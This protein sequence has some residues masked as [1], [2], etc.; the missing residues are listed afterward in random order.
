MRTKL[1]GSTCR[2]K[3][4]KNSVPVRVI[5]LCLPRGR[6]P[7]TGTSRA[8]VR[9]PTSGDWKSPRG[10]CSA[11]DSATPAAGHRRRAWHKPPSRGDGDDGAVLQTVVGRR[12]RQPGPHTVT[13][14]DGGGVSDRRGTCR[15]RRDSR[16]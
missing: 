2:K 14:Y 12:E 7:S 8:L 11:P 3:R 1:L 9:R 6:N 15:E 5:W 16:L 13:S 10:G 4:R